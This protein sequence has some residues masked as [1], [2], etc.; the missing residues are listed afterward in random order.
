IGF[1][2][3]LIGI[4][5]I[6]IR[7]VNQ[8]EFGR[9]GN[10]KN[11]LIL[12]RPIHVDEHLSRLY[13]V[14]FFNWQGGW[15]ASNLGGVVSSG[16]EGYSRSSARIGRRLFGKLSQRYWLRYEPLIDRGISSKCLAGILNPDC[17]P[18]LLTWMEIGHLRGSY[19]DPCPLVQSYGIRKYL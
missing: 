1:V 17:G 12:Y 19:P 5:A 6:N 3:A 7:L 9:M 13:V 14:K 18:H 11:V 16:K 4:E 10:S 2:V 8:G 15:A